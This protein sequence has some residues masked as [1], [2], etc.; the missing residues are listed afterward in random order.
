MFVAITYRTRPGSATM[1]TLLIKTRNPNSATGGK[2]WNLLLC[3]DGSVITHFGSESQS[4]NGQTRILTGQGT[5][6]ADAVGE[7]RDR[8]VDKGRRGYYFSS[9]TIAEYDG[10]ASQSE[11]LGR[12]TP[13]TRVP[14]DESAMFSEFTST[15]REW[16]AG[17]AP[18]APSVQNRPTALTVDGQV[19]RPNGQLYR[20]R[21]LGGHS[22]VAACR[23]M[24]SHSIPYLIRGLPGV[25][26]SALAEAS[27]T[28]VAESGA[29]QPDFEYIAGDGDMT[30]AKLVGTY[31][32]DS[33]GGWDWHD[34][35]LTTAMRHGRVLLFDDINRAPAE[36]LAVLYS[37]MD[38]TP[39]VLRL[40]DRPDAELVTA[41]PGFLVVGTANL[42]AI[43]A[44]VM[45]EA[46]TSRFCVQIEA[47]TDYDAARA[48]G[49]SSPLVTL[50]ENLTTRSNESIKAGGERVW[51]PQMRELLATKKI[52]DAGLGDQFAVAALINMC[53]YPEQTPVVVDAAKQA[54]GYTTVGLTLG[55]Q[56]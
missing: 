27:N 1:L 50:A 22:D 7:A 54:L 32:P 53:P 42:D 14:V 28:T 36:V 33:S 38:R 30:V 43:G 47:T 39:G 40:A 52:T 4:G 3:A 2:Y 29:P 6:V 5:S 19:L 20:C 34:G 13:L 44:G 17:P 55:G 24:R 18:A 15:A 37:A 51:A 11:M 8:Y 41:A 46:L 21:D 25:G 10:A 31:L 35:P 12:G 49:V 9:A 45:D 48:L 16:T 26:K 23:T 56:L